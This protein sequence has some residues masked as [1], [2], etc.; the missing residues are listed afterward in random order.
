MKRTPKYRNEPLG[1][2]RV[3]MDF[4]PPPE[5]LVVRDEGVKI[6]IGLSRH[7]VDFFKERAARANVPYQK[8]IRALLDSYARHFAAEPPP[9]TPRPRRT[10]Q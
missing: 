4:L 2:V 10:S 1:P 7:S 6:T 9:T 3:V 5:E 8:M